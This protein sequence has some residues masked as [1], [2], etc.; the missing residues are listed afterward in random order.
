VPCWVGCDCH[1]VVAGGW[2]SLLARLLSSLMGAPKPGS[3]AP[4]PYARMES[5]HHPR[6]AA[7]DLAFSRL[8]DEE[9]CLQLRQLAGHDLEAV[10][11]AAKRAEIKRSDYISDRTF[12]LLSAVADN[13]PVRPIEPALAGLFG[14]EEAIGRLPLQRAFDYLAELEP[15][16]RELERM[17]PDPP[18][19]P[20]SPP[21]SN[22]AFGGRRAKLNER[23]SLTSDLVGIRARSDRPLLR[24]DI[25]ASI[26]RQYL[27]FRD[28]SPCE[29]SRAY[30]DSPQLGSSSGELFDGVDR[31]EATS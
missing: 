12:R 3:E 1:Q 20:L 15:A 29:L 2:L 7:R 27:A 21:G 19:P 6:W 30:F 28:E 18:L 26:V 9:A 5:E 4:G 10:R 31:P 11:R 16:L 24:S 22:G 25:S 17:P 8:S 13:K 23:R 14:E